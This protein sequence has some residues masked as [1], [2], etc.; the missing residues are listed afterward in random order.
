MGMSVLGDE[1]IIGK[2]R[3]NGLEIGQHWDARRYVEARDD[4]IR[5][6]LATQGKLET[7]RHPAAIEAIT[8]VLTTSGLGH[9]VDEA[10]V[11]TA[12]RR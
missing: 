9:L 8:R 12:R 10:V 5:A 3:R 11:L 4:D 1:R 6:W 7:G 2:L